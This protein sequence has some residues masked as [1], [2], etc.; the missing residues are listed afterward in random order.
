[1]KRSIFY[2][3]TNWNLSHLG[4][5]LL[6]TLVCYWPLAFGVFSAKNDNIVQFLPVRFQVSEALRNG[7]LPLWSPYMYLGYPVYGDMQGGA[8]NPVVW[9][10][11]LFG[12][13]N[14]TS[15]HAE[16]LF[17]IF[18]GGAGMYRLLGVGDISPRLRL[19]GAAAYLMCGY[20]TDVGGSNLPFLAVV[21][22]IPFVLTYYYRLL[23]T[24]SMPYAWKTA[25]ALALLFVS[26]YP[27][28]FITT[29]YILLAGLM[30]VLVRD[31]IHHKKINISRQ[32]KCNMVLALVFLGLCAP[33][34][35]SYAQVLPFYQRGSGVGLAGALQNS[36]HPS[37][38]LS[39]LLPPAPVKE[40]AALGSDL[41]SRN[42]Y[43]NSFFLLFVVCYA[44]ARKR[45]WLNF[46]A[47]GMLFFFLFSLGAATP[48][49]S[50]CYHILPLM[51][52]FRHPSN[53]RLFVILAGIVLGAGVCQQWLTGELKAKYPFRVC[54]VLMAGVVVALFV[55]SNPASLLQKLQALNT[56][57][58]G[59]RTALKGLFDRLDFGDLV[60]INGALQLVFLALFLFMLLRQKFTWLPVVFIANSLLFAQLSLPY[61][62]VSKVPPRV[63]NQIIRNFLPSNQP[64]DLNQSIGVS[65]LNAL[66]YFDTLGITAFY[67]K[68]ISTTNIVF[69]PTFMTPIEELYHD[70]ATLRTVL[71]NPYAYLASNVSKEAGADVSGTVITNDSNLLHV[72]P[73]QGQLQ[74]KNFWNNNFSFH[75]SSGIS[76]VL[77]FQQLYLPGWTCTIDGKKVVPAKAN[78]AFMAVA[79]PAGQ[80]EVVFLY[81]PRG[82]KIMLLIW[83]FSCWIILWLLNQ[84]IRE[85]NRL[86]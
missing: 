25:I 56:H 69:T 81:S 78:H 66:E 65:S 36:F 49:R 19:A 8:W 57:E 64:P 55:W 74:L 72:V 29:C 24:L 71:S 17:Y 18:V 46:V 7:H 26:G 80:H 76:T 12:R 77:C 22:Y 10:L 34:I 5:L 84:R 63:A 83:L 4:L 41:I 28:F 37:C 1:M 33:A 60:F 61:T 50:W 6:L 54:L 15:I 23:T 11:S 75:T 68:N 73:G 86:R 31:L 39:F 43:F 82:L 70:S 51:N 59:W 45:L 13:Y 42:A 62:F 20:I 67:H 3:R 40:V 16:I 44:V 35:F 53:A 52:T 85:K 2:Q 14:V 30:T 48:L 21:A 9:L 58:G 79:V 27:S 38:S 47:V 32:L